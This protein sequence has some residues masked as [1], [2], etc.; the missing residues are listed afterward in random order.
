MPQFYRMAA[1]GSRELPSVSHQ[2]KT[3]LGRTRWEPTFRR[4]KSGQVNNRRESVA[5]D[6]IFAATGST[7]N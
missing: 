6:R 7:N 5:I 1:G 4:P 2:G 3:R